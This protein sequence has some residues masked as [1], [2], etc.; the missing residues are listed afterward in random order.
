MSGGAG[1]AG[2]ADALVEDEAGDRHAEEDRGLAQRRHHGDRGLGHRPEG[3]AVG[4]E[5]ADAADEAE[6][7]VAADGG[8]KRP[9]A[10]E[11]RPGDEGDAR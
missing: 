1:E 9:A 2:G 11:E 5:V 7:P 6:A 4:A 10:G 3:E 8:E